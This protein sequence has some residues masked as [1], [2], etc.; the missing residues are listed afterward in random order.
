M[1]KERKTERGREREGWGIE[2]VTER[3]MEGMEGCGREGDRE[4]DGGS[5]RMGKRGREMEG[6]ERWG[7]EGVTQRERVREREREGEERMGKG[8]GEIVME[9]EG[10]GREGRR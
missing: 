9:K 2:G 8:G 1:G 5:G 3:E 7:R 4:R 10:W 6:V